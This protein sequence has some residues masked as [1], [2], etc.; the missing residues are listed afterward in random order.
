MTAVT[1]TG[2]AGTN[3]RLSETPLN[4]RTAMSSNTA[5]ASGAADAGPSSSRSNGCDG[6]NS[7]GTGS[8]SVSTGCSLQTSTG[9][10]RCS[11]SLI[12]TVTNI[13]IPR[14]N[15]KAQLNGAQLTWCGSCCL[16][17]G[18]AFIEGGTDGSQT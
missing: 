7:A 14:S 3:S 9:V 17:P 16:D 4:A 18:H 2:G 5:T 13:R 12:E 8:G 10:G 15:R 6:S 1:S 11:W